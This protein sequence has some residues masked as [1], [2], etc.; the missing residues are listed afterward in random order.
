LTH[1]ICVIFA[2]SFV[3]ASFVVFHIEERV[4][5][6]KHLHF[7]SGVHPVT[8]WIAA[9]LWDFGLYLITAT[10]CVF[11]F[12]VFDAQ[13]YVSE[14]NLGSL[15][16][17]LFLYGW[18]SIPLMYPASFIFS[19]PSSA[20]VTLSCVNLFIGII[21]TIT[22]FV[23]ENFDDEELKNIGAIL[24]KVFLIF[25]HYCLG[26][27]LM[28]M[29][30]E[31]TL[32]NA[33]SVLGLESNRK[34]FDFDFLGKY[35]FY[36]FLQGIVFF[37]FTLLLQS[38]FWTYWF[39]KAEGPKEKDKQSEN[40]DEDVKNERNRV[41]KGEIGDDVMQ[42]KNLFKRYK[43]KGKQAVDQL[44]FGVHKAECFGLLGAMIL[45]VAL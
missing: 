31:H 18:S 30:T 39:S 36:M 26:R 28:D 19:I 3:P 20:F 10:L 2:L 13:A 37:A 27:G 45:Q 22:T 17:L 34:R 38:K 32:N 44:T 4:S 23:L 42:V 15:V 25:P 1:A 43:R 14:Q 7:V 29:A 40:E 11:I 6:V 16:L 5:K 24:R 33:I 21:T 12:L 8:Y 9:I 35:F 41:L